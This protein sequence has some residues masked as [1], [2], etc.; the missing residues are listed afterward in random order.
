MAYGDR[1]SRNTF[2]VSLCR[3][4]FSKTS[5][6]CRPLLFVSDRHT[7]YQLTNHTHSSVHNLLD[8]T[9][10]TE[11]TLRMLRSNKMAGM[12]VIKMVKDLCFCIKNEKR[13]G[14]RCPLPSFTQKLMDKNG[15]S[16][17]ELFKIAF[18][19]ILFKEIDRQ[20]KRGMSPESDVLSHVLYIQSQNN[21]DRLFESV[22]LLQTLCPYSDEI[23][24]FL[25]SL[26]SHSSEPE[27]HT[28]CYCQN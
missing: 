10:S 9:G 12:S 7:H 8:F 15:I 16:D 21:K 11:F 20:S 13:E 22:P 26:S 18:N 1:E 14:M 19:V 6:S 3:S 23:F 24:V 2:L 17:A 5:S 27:V 25:S 4:L 28:M